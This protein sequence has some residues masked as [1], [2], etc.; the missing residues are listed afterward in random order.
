MDTIGG[1]QIHVRDICVGL[2]S[3]GH[4]ISVVMGGNESH[5]EEFE[6]NEIEQINSKYLIRQ[7]NLITDIKAFI[8]IR[9]IIKRIKPDLIATHSSKAGIIG[10]VIGW[11][12]HIPTIF[13]AH[14]WSFT[15]GVTRKKKRMYLLIEKFV[16]LISDGVITVSEYDKQ[17]ALKHK[18]LP[19]EKIITIHNGV[20]ETN[21]LKEVR[22]R[23]D[24]INLIMVARFAPPKKQLDLLK[25]LTKIQE[26]KWKML[27][28]G[29][30]I[31]RKE[32]EEFVERE[33][34]NDR[35][36]FLGNR[37]DVEEVLRNSHIFILLSDWEGLPLSILEA[38]RSGLPIIASDVG[39]VK[40]AVVQSV[41]GFM[42][43]R[44]DERELISKLTLLLTSP[45]LRLEMGNRSRELYQEHFKFEQMYEKTLYFYKE[46]SEAGNA[47]YLARE[48]KA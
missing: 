42:V 6:S 41:N 40:E 24:E 4:S 21:R 7:L 39:G 45:P 43:A 23:S 3:S 10:R 22:F 18:V 25:A 35:V 48:E 34:L 38:M 31:L 17:L 11:S 20:H 26:Y 44:N 5:Y 16:G 8:E 1:A 33:E 12:L 37:N 30:G 32:A 19:L 9:K 47:K 46:V 29:D 27:F 2:K 36:Q 28:V 14:G 15:E 13:T